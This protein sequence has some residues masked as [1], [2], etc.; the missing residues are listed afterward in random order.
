MKTRVTALIENRAPETFCGEHG[1]SFWIE[2]GDRRY[3]LDTGATGAFVLNAKA[4]GI[5][6]DQADAVIISHNHYDHMGGL[7]AFF[8]VNSQAKVYIRSA[9][10]GRFYFQGKHHRKDIGGREGLLEEYRDRFCFVD[11]KVTLSEGAVLLPDGPADPQYAGREEGFM[12]EIAGNL[13]PDLFLHEQSLVL[14]T[15]DGLTLFNSCSHS[16]IVNIVGN[17]RGWLP[18]KPV[19]RVFGGFHMMIVGTDRMNCPPEYVEQV[20]RRLAELGVREIYTGHCTGVPAF[21]HLRETLGNGIHY[22]QT[23]DTVEL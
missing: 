19:I 1:L 8:A 10:R 14:D 15:G 22:F 16:G 4:M 11:G 17:V 13:G 9:A 23:G 20:G 3:L 12:A 21:E 6:L 18:D 5:P 2:Y 7:D